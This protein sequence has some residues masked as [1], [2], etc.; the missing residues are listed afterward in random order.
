M[1]LETAAARVLAYVNEELLAGTPLRASLDTPLFEEGWIDSM[2]ILKLIAFVE[3]LT[4][5]EISD[6]LVVMKNFR[7]VRTIVSTFASEDA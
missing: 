4:G 5:R 3:T 1:S 2:K 7:C 6:E